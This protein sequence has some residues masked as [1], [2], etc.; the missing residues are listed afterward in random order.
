MIALTMI[1]FARLHRQFLDT[2]N[3]LHVLEAIQFAHH[4]SVPLPVWV[5]DY[6]ATFAAN[7]LGGT[8]ADVALG[9]RIKGG[10]SKHRQLARQARDLGIISYIEFCLELTPDDWPADRALPP[11]LLPLK[12]GETQL[13]I[14]CDI[15]A[16][17]TRKP[18]NGFSRTRLS[19]TTIRKIYERATYK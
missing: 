17:E 15:V 3:G 13:S 14:V 7:V 2:R 16:A 10:H 5:V 4:A 6:L 12:R 11:F 8:P 1:V 18:G 19:A 9:L